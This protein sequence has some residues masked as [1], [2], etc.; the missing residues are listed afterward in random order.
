ML[1]YLI[2]ILIWVAIVV[3]AKDKIKNKIKSWLNIQSVEEPKPS[4][5]VENIEREYYDLK[6]MLDMNVLSIKD[7]M[8]KKIIRKSEKIEEKIKE[9]IIK[10]EHDKM[11]INVAELFNKT[12]NIIKKLIYNMLGRLQNYFK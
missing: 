2:L 7:E 1:F 8:S 3:L 5:I 10:E 12:W 6:N 9:D 4:F 11:E